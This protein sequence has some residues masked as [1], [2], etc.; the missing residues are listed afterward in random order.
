MGPGPGDNKKMDP[1]SDSQVICEKLFYR[2][3]KSNAILHFAELQRAHQHDGQVV[4]LH[5]RGHRGQPDQQEVLQGPGPGDPAGQGGRG[6]QDHGDG[7][8][9]PLDQGGPQTDEA[10]PGQPLLHRGHPSSRRQVLGRGDL[11]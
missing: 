5:H 4:Q 10:V 11:Q 1:S 2:K 9:P 6:D 7:D 8:Q 3:V